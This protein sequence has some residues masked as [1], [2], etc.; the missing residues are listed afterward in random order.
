MVAIFIFSS[1]DAESSSQKS[2]FLTLLLF[3]NAA[4]EILVRKSAHIIVFAALGFCFANTLKYRLKGRKLFLISVCLTS[5]Y[6]VTD[7]VHQIFVPGR[8]GRFEDWLIDTAGALIGVSLAF[9]LW[10][11]D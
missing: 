1:F 5:F 10:N 3:G 7:E 9:I 11:H 2:S 6:A 8:S 4:L